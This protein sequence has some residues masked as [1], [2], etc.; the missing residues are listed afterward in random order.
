MSI[1]A[2]PSWV[3]MPG[4][5]NDALRVEE[6]APRTRFDELFDELFDGVVV[7]LLLAMMD[8]LAVGDDD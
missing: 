2:A 1:T 3:D 4:A 8:F 5:V 6:T 7:A